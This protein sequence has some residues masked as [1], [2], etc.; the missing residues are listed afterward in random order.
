MRIDIKSYAQELKQALRY[1]VITAAAPYPQLLIVQI[2]D[3]P[4]SNSYVKGKLKDAE[5]IMVK[6]DWAKFNNYNS[7]Y[8]YISK[9][10]YQYHGIILQEPS[11]LSDAERTQIL[12]L[13]EPGQDVDGFKLTSPYTPC[14][15]AAIMDI[16]THFYNNDSK[17]LKGT[18]VT[19][20]GR[21][22][23]VGKPLIPLLVAAGATVICCNSTTP[24]LKQFTSV[25]DI[26]VSATGK[27]MLITR[28]MLKD[29]AFVVDAGIYVDENGKLHG[30]CDKAMYDDPNIQIT[31]VPGGVGLMTRVHLMKNVEK[32]RKG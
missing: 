32:S 7:A 17:D 24:D 2:G 6:A 5:E 8:N 26:V 18:V 31:T 22:E 29:G 28:D 4:A 30:D 21:G 16:I 11:G 15:P 13:I 14:T 27:P 19:V 3:N 1:R 23:L 20:V 10:G 12:N 25:A 9:L